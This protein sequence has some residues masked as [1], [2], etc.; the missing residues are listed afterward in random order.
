MHVV[1]TH[2]MY[3]SKFEPHNN[4]F[5]NRTIRQLTMTMNPTVGV[6]VFIFNSQGQ[7]VVG[8]RKGSHGAGTYPHTFKVLERY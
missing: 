2:A 8:E 7:F 4:S 1:M 3:I 6:G 5:H